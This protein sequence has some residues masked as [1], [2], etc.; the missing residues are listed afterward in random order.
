MQGTQIPPPS[1]LHAT[2]TPVET[3]KIKDFIDA[4]CQNIN[5]LTAKDLSKIL[6]QSTQQARLCTNLVLM[7][8][9]RQ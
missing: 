7:S 5:P 9:R 2:I 8:Y 3:I 6:D 4:S 1:P